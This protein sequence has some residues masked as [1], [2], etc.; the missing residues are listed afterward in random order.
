MQTHKLSS[1]V[2]CKSFILKDELARWLQFAPTYHEY[3]LYSDGSQ[4]APQR[5]RVRTFVPTGQEMETLRNS[6]I[7]FT[8][9]LDESGSESGSPM[10]EPQKPNI[11]D[12]IENPPLYEHHFTQPYDRS[13]LDARRGGIASTKPPLPRRSMDI[14]FN[15]R[16]LYTP[17][18][19][20][21]GFLQSEGANDGVENLD[22][23]KDARRISQGQGQGNN[24]W[25]FGNSNQTL[26]NLQRHDSRRFS[27][28]EEANEL[29]KLTD[30]RA[31]EHGALMDTIDIR[32]ENDEYQ[33]GFIQR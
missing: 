15:P 1:Y 19:R 3:V 6:K 33:E 23:T 20:R 21:G 7:S 29:T 10:G 14:D 25:T 24:Q 22:T 26:P 17:E 28:G 27:S 16:A 18:A 5:Y 13:P 9:K 4:E 8:T 12:L 2:V 32:G 31:S 11:D 30:R